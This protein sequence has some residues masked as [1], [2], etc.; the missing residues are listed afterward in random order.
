MILNQKII[1]AFHSKGSIKNGTKKCMKINKFRL[2]HHLQYTVKW[3]VP[4][5]PTIYNTIN[6]TKSCVQA[7]ISYQFQLSLNK[8]SSFLRVI[9]II[10]TCALMRMQTETWPLEITN[11]MRFPHTII[12]LNGPFLQSLHFCLLRIGL[13]R[14]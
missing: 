1:D 12:Y 8:R 14:F 6:M 7:T 13:Q 5:S 10:A 9:L 11:G 2:S 3:D 4:E